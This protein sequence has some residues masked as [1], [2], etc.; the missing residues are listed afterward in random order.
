MVNDDDDDD[1]D[2]E[3]MNNHHIH[4]HILIRIAC[5]LECR[6][7]ETTCFNNRIT[8]PLNCKSRW[9][10]SWSRIF[11][12]E[13]EQDKSIRSQYEESVRDDDDDDDESSLEVGEFMS[14]S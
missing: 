6:S 13:Q 9:C 7:N 2:D 10:D 4:N 14:L 11:K 5:W 12:E 8:F 3:H 1:D